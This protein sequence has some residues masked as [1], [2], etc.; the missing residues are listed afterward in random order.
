MSEAV[1]IAMKIHISQFIALFWLFAQMGVHALNPAE[2]EGQVTVE[3]D[4][5]KPVW[6]VTVTNHSAQKLSYEMMGKVPRGLGLEVWDPDN[7]DG[8]SPK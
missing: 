6:I 1:Y 3:V 7:C 5:S 8:V 4:R 2:V